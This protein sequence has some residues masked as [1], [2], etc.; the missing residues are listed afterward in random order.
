[1]SQ[2]EPLFVAPRPPFPNAELP[3][4]VY[5]QVLKPGEDFAVLFRKN[6]WTGIWVNGVYGFDHFHADAHEALGCVSGWAR[7]RLGGPEGVE[8]TL[9]AGDA[10]LLPAGM[11]HRNMA[12]S[13]DFSIVGAYPP[14]Q[15]P[16]LRRGDMAAYAGLLARARAVPLPLTDPVLGVDGAV[17]RH[18]QRLV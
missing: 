10:V 5:P 15:K 17:R 18:W 7:I 13:E 11:G 2:A 6:G 4:L 9:R 1:M 3:V 14:G 12:Q 8:V 16:D